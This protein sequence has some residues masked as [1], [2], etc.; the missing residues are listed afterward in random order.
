MG[1]WIEDVG[2][3]GEGM[4]LVGVGVLALR[5]PILMRDS[6]LEAQKRGVLVVAEVLVMTGMR[7]RGVD[8]SLLAGLHVEAGRKRSLFKML[9]RGVGGR[10]S[11]GTYIT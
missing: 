2:L 1:W 10:G 6:D 9:R 7:C 4:R 11:G 8:T 5:I 3:W